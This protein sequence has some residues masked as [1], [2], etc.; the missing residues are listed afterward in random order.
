MQTMEE[1]FKVVSVGNAGFPSGAN[2]L[3]MSLFLI[4]LLSVS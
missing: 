3:E 4:F 2:K 1:N